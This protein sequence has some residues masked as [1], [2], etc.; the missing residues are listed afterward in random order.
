MKKRAVK[1]RN[2]VGHEQEAG[3]EKDNMLAFFFIFFLQIMDLML[4]LKTAGDIIVHDR[5]SC[6]MPG[7]LYRLYLLNCLL[8]VDKFYRL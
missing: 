2:A 1:E 4:T 3:D 8:V 7:H 5:I 6:H